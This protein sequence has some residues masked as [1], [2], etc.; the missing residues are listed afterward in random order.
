V[1]H[2]R[3]FR[4]RRRLALPSTASRGQFLLSGAHSHGAAAPPRAA[5]ARFLHLWGPTWTVS[6]ADRRR[7]HPRARY[8]RFAIEVQDETDVNPLTSYPRR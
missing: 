5:D 2:R 7:V 1:G 6:A 3:A 8:A 4:E